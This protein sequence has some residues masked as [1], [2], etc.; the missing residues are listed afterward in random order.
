MHALFII[1]FGMK[2][3]DDDDD[4]DEFIVGTWFFLKK[5]IFF[6]LQVSEF[7]FEVL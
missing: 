1:K 4:D 7:A 5:N 6:V 2:Q 3:Y